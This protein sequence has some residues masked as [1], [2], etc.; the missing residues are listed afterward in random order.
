MLSV[1]SVR[2]AHSIAH[3]TE[4]KLTMLAID[5]FACSAIPTRSDGMLR[6]VYVGLSPAIDDNAHRD[7][8]F[9][10]GGDIGGS[11]DGQ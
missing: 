2:Q 5:S 11:D 7:F 8:D 4:R 9:E 1:G 6:Q 10:G 3:C